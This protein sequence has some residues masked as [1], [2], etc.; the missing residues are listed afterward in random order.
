MNYLEYK[1]KFKIQLNE[2]QEKAVL[3]TQGA[4]LLLAVPGSGK[5]TVIVSRIGYMIYC[6]NIKPENILTLTYSVA[7]SED[8]K[9]RFKKVFGEEQIEK[10]KFSTINSFCLTI[11]K[12]Y[13]K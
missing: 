3:D 10:I 11:L 7:A 5:T 9:E 13:E 8:M 12:K 4:I 1:N 6:L 2:Q